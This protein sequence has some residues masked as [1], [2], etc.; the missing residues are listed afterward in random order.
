MAAG[1]LKTFGNDS[2]GASATA[3]QSEAYRSLLTARSQ[4]PTAYCLLPTE[5]P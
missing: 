5:L 3:R 4:P 2:F 1:S